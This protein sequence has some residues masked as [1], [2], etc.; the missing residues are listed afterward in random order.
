M[1]SHPALDCRQTTGCLPRKPGLR[2]CAAIVTLALA[3]PV[4]AATNDSPRQPRAFTILSG[5][6]PRVL[7]GGSE[8]SAVPLTLR[9][10]GSARWDPAIG[11]ALSYHWR[12]W[13]NRLVERDGTRTL[14]PHPVPPGGTVTL[15]A[16]LGLPPR[17]GLYVLEW[18]MVQEHVAWFSEDGR[19]SPSRTFV[20]VV[21]NP[22]LLGGVLPAVPACLAAL[23]LLLLVRRERRALA[24]GGVRGRMTQGNPPE[25]GFLAAR[26]LPVADL[27]WCAT[28][29]FVKQLLLLSGA[30]LRATPTG[31]LGAAITSAIPALLLFALF[32]GRARARASWLVAAGGALLLLA[33][34][35]YYRYFGD[36]L[37]ASAVSAA[38]QAGHVGASIRSLLHPEDA[39]LVVDLLLAMPLLSRLRATAW[40]R[41]TWRRRAISVSA[42]GV[43]LLIAAPFA[44]SPAFGKAAAEGLFRHLAVVQDVGVFSYHLDDGV[45]YART[46]LRHPTFTPQEIAETRRWFAQ[47][48]PTRAGTGPLFGA[49]RGHSLVTVL[50]ESLQGF[51]LG[52]KVNGQEITPTLNRLR[53][54]SIWSSRVVDQVAEGR[55]SDAE[56]INAVSLLPLLRGAA[57]FEYPGHSFLALPQLLADRGYHT[58]SAVPFEASFWNRGVTH[59]AYGFERRLF[60]PDFEPGE[61]VGWGLN[62]RSFLRQM[63]PRLRAMPRP[64]CAWLITLSLHHPFDSFPESLASLDLGRL[65]GTRLGNYL[66]AMHLFDQGLG[67]FVDGLRRNGVLE[68]TLLVVEGDHEA[69]APWEEVARAAG[70]HRDTLDWYLADRVPLLIRVPGEG[71]PRGE[72]QVVAG[73]ADIPPTLLAL[74]GIDP[75]PLPF[76]GRNLLGTPGDHAVVRRYGDWIDARHLYLAGNGYSTRKACFDLASRQE[77]SLAECTDGEADAAAQV[78]VSSRVLTGGL[79]RSLLAPAGRARK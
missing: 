26:A 4:L 57:A 61:Q 79:Q 7:I 73:Q 12:T 77:V 52:L 24:R 49:A 44:G 22:A 27:A 14:L 8:A 74:L 64:F 20:L 51:V 40:P 42:L 10:D 5:A 18:D 60:A 2:A 36:V 33:D 70:F 53:A 65:N 15:D 71:G 13:R 32:P 56:L 35:V 68:D 19:A 29:L 23:F 75:A 63:V 28:S 46:W 9:N 41:P 69:G 37:S 34:L 48:A 50:V 59:A 66:Q 38:W 21:P 6:T 16:E 11:Y 67:D 58:V 55:T 31:V 62:D 43:C 45:R 76:I 1:P 39:W 78:Q 17:A 25:A 54:E 3:G 30:H 72:L 47:R